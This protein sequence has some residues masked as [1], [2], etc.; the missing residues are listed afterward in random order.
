MPFTFSHPAIILPF[1]N[2]IGKRLSMTGLIVGSLTPDF[3]YFIRMKIQSEFSHTFFGTIWFNLPLGIILCFLFHQIIKKPFIENL[4]FKI[5][6]KFSE[7]KNS[8][9]LDYFKEKWLVVIISIVIGT[10]SHIL[11]DSFTHNNAYFVNL[12]N[13]NKTVGGINLPIYKVLQHAST[14]IGG[15]YILNYIWNM[16]EVEIQTSRPKLN[17][18]VGILFFTGIIL[19]IKMITGLKL[20]QYGNVIASMISAFLVSTIIMSLIQRKKST[21]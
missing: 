12:L 5:Q 21:Y 18:W 15:I 13:L 3:E 6:R 1:K 20:S 4:P 19:A 10:F 2:S 17:Y 9:W 11:W 7:I 14:L 16:N 8:N